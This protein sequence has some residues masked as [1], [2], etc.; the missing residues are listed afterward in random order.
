MTQGLTCGSEVVGTLYSNYDN[1]LGV[2]NDDF[3]GVGNVLSYRTAIPN[4][5]NNVELSCWVTS[6]L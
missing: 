4:T 3:C 2:A 1:R 6:P 5:V